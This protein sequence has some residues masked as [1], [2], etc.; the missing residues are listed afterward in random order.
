MSLFLLVTARSQADEILFDD[1]LRNGW[2]NWSWADV[3]MANSS[4]AQT[5]LR[6]IR[7]TVDAWE[8]L[9]LHH[10]P[11]DV[12]GFTNL[13]F[14]IHGGSAGGQRLMLQ[15]VF[16]SAP[17]ADGQAIGPLPAG[18]WQQVQVPIS[19]LVPPG[20][21]TIDG[22]WIQDQTGNTQPALYVDEIRLLAGSS[23][24]PPTNNPVSIRVNAQA[25]RHPINPEIYGVAFAGPNALRELNVPLNRSG[26]NATTRYNWQANA[27][28]RASDWYFESLASSSA[29]PGADSDEFIA[30]CQAAGAQ[31]MLTI[32]IIGWVAKLGPNRA[33][34]CSFSIAK[35]GAQT[36]NDWQWFPD[37]G[38]GISAATGQP[39]SGND[40]DD[41]NL[42]VDTEYQAG[43]IR[44]LTNRWGTATNGG[45]SYYILDNE[46]SLW[47]ETH[48]DVHPVGATM[49]EVRDR[50]LD[51][52]AMIKAID[53]SAR[54]VGPEEWGWSGYLYSGYDLQWGSTHGWGGSLPDRTAHDGADF[55]PWFLDQVRRRSEA[56]GT[57][58]LD[59]F[60]VHY[61]PQ[62]G[63]FGGGVD[64]AQQLRR[65]RSTRSLWDPNY[66]DESWINDE[67]QLI[68]RLKQ[69]VA[70]YYPETP[71]AITEYSWGAESHINGATTQAD[72]LGIFGREGLDLATRWVVPATGSPTFKAF[73][74]YRNYDGQHSTFGE[75]SIAAIV[76]DPDQLSAFAAERSSDGAFTLIAINKILSGST[77]VDVTIEGAALSGSAQVWQLTAANLITRLPDV[78]LSSGSFT[79]TLPAQSITLVVVPTDAMLPRWTVGTNNPP[80]QMELWLEGQAGRSYVVES[81]ADLTSWAFDSNHTLL[82]N[83]LQIFVPR[84]NIARFFRAQSVP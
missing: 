13:V 70:Q 39:I 67:V 82:T 58:L 68:P 54:I 78:P 43:W 64:T 71:V 7:I 69:W 57:R 72:V 31:P 2:A 15:A 36:G 4:P 26:G 83:S 23:P 32:P 5:G 55:L 33:R 27:S 10:T 1:T 77:P 51:H 62:G 74:M 30:D 53:P 11:F 22:F 16:D 19:V 3:D 46:W 49:E 29:T 8:A 61:Y 20:Q 76:P 75:T 48:R 47:H 41:A 56:T 63:E 17:V 81:S 28:N 35:Y 37:A 84:T 25:N 44:H 65:N 9:Y 80:G 34:L 73:Q 12:S 14:W 42:R 38:N 66:T 79:N 59:V 6:S 40:P 45:L 24:P 21:A 60:T 18:I 50:F 52:A